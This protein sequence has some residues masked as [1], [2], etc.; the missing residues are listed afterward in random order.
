MPESSV[1]VA[2]QYAEAAFQLAVQE[3]KVEGWLEELRV[4]ANVLGEDRVRRGLDSP[5]I[6]QSEKIRIVRYSLKGLNPLV[7]NLISLLVERHRLGLLPVVVAE[8][9]RLLDARRGVVT[10]EVTTAV[11]LDSQRTALV[12]QRLSSMLGKQVRLQTVVDQS[13]IGGLIVRVGDKLINGSIAGR[14]ASLRQELA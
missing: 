5:S 13:I 8:F 3:N 4:A 11:P 14:L 7:L 12:A 6:G 9:D 1:S 10:A 2:R